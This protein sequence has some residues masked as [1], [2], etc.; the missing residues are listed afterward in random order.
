MSLLSAMINLDN[1][2]K[3]AYYEVNFGKRD[4]IGLIIIVLSL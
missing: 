1:N 4:D 2:T 3:Q